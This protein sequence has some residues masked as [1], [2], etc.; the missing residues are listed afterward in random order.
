MKE[1][2]KMIYRMVMVKRSGRMAIITKVTIKQ[3]KRMAREFINGKM[4]VG[5][6]G[7]TL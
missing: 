7:T 3:A 6:K 5:M 2:G 4:E 1:S